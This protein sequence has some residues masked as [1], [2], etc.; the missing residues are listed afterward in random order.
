MGYKGKSN[1][2]ERDKL[3]Q[4]SLSGKPVNHQEVKNN[5][6][7][8]FKEKPKVG[9]GDRCAKGHAWIRDFD[10]KEKCAY[11]RTPRPVASS[12]KPPV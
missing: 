5:L 6:K 4:Q 12:S 2:D 3:F 7:E 9:E 10:R 1:Y 8:L 11:C